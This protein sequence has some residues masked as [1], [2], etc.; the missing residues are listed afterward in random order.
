MSSL[1]WVSKVY[2]VPNWTGH[3]CTC[4]ALLTL[5]LTALDCTCVH[6]C[7][8]LLTLLLTIW[9]IVPCYCEFICSKCKLWNQWLVN[10]DSLSAIIKQR[11]TK[12]IHTQPKSTSDSSFT[13]TYFSWTTT[14]TRTRWLLTS[15]S[16]PDVYRGPKNTGGYH[17][18]LEVVLIWAFNQIVHDG[19]WVDIFVVRLRLTNFNL[20]AWPIPDIEE[21]SD[22]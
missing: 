5:L 6:A 15:P 3:V 7:G 16:I 17:S 9:Q 20:E 13:N 2:Q 19:V 1:P 8:M 18:T 22:S 11:N 10:C 14:K 12:F 4:G 21:G